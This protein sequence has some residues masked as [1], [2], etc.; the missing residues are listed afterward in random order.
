MNKQQ[1]DKWLEQQLLKLQPADYVRTYFT[2]ATIWRIPETVRF[3]TK[4]VQRYIIVPV[5]VYEH[6]GPKDMECIGFEIISI[7]SLAAQCPWDM[8]KTYVK[9]D[10][11]NTHYQGNLHDCIMESMPAHKRLTALEAARNIQD[12]DVEYVYGKRNRGPEGATDCQGM[13]AYS[14]I[15]PISADM[16]KM[17]EELDKLQRAVDELKGG[18]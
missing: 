17:R 6:M 1:A 10:S 5:D 16:D 15:A 2:M 11:E 8:T 13:T 12:A 14:T 3:E 7:Q 4:D 18:K 9:L